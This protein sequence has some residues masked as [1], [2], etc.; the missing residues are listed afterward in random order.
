MV[1]WH[2]LFCSHTVKALSLSKYNVS[3][4]RGRQLFLSVCQFELNRKVGLFIIRDSLQSIEFIALSHPGSCATTR[5]LSHT[6]TH[7]QILLYLRR[8]L[9]SIQC[10]DSEV[11][12]NSVYVLAEWFRGAVSVCVKT[13]AIKGLCNVE[14]ILALIGTAWCVGVWCRDS[15]LLKT[16]GLSFSWHMVITHM[17]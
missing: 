14:K 6:S 11:V 2:F 12:A 13:M 10:E 5:L 9:R 8:H 15:L 3:R 4:G 17:L 7:M 1:L 16:W